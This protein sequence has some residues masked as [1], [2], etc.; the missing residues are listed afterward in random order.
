M[1]EKDYIA[2]TNKI[3]SYKYGPTLVI[4]TNKIITYFVYSCY[5][6]VLLYLMVNKDDRW[7]AVLVGPLIVF[8]GVSLIRSFMNKPRPYELYNYNQILRKNSPG[9]SFPSRHV[10]S[11][12]VI[13]VSI[14]F[15]SV[16]L[17]SILLVM[18]VILAILR[19]IGG[20]HFPLDVIVGAIAG[21]LGAL[22]S[23]LV[24]FTF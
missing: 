4:G 2:I 8:T 15:V 18:G 10:F 1:K 11:I 16:P 20:V 23:W 14:I 24:Y 21:I 17:G 9:K 13:A 6:L 3:N 5:P 19:V 22:L 12:F 7:M